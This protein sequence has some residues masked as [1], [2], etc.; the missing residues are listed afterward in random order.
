MTNESKTMEPDSRH[1]DAPVRSPLARGRRYQYRGFN[2]GFVV[3]HVT[4]RGHVEDDGGLEGVA[5]RWTGFPARRGS[6]FYPFKSEAAFWKH[7]LFRNAY[8]APQIKR[9]RRSNG[10][11][12]GRAACGESPASGGSASEPSRED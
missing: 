4:F 6:G 12:Q 1:L 7:A 8:D 11:L 3:K 9:T 2:S 5:I 10:P